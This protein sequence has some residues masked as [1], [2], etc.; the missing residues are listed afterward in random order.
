MSGAQS[1]S[2]YRRMVVGVPLGFAVGVELVVAVVVTVGVDVLVVVA[3]VVG[4][5]V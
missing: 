3:V 1:P 2:R 4:D 5:E